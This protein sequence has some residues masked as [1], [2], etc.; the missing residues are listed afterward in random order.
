MTK[1]LC[2]Y[3]GDGQTA[4]KHEQSGAEIKTD[5]PL[6]NG[7]KG[8]CFSPTD[9]FASSLAACF[10]TI[11]G[12]MASSKGQDLTSAQIEIEKI[13]YADPRRVGKLILKVTFPP[14]IAELDKKKYLAALRACPVH[15]SLSKEIE[16]ELS[17]N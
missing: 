1:I 17:S 5:L 13:M 10:M 6:D 2:T 12:K 4:L 3:T 16:L 15:N 9:L 7:G 8:R 14:A 11:M